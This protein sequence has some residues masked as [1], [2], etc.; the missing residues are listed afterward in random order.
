MHW[1]FIKEPA[2]D[3]P[4]RPSFDRNIRNGIKPL[5][6][7]NGSLDKPTFNPSIVM[8]PDDVHWRCHS[9]VRE[10]MIQFLSDCYHKLASQTVEL[11]DVH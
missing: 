11:P 3:S 10:G 4:N 6:Y 8:C 7:W 9:F 5:W 2:L 1:V